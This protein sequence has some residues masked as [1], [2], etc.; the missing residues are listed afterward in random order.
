MEAGRQELG[1]VLS[2]PLEGFVRLEPWPIKRYYRADMVCQVSSR[3][4]EL[5]RLMNEPDIM[6]LAM[7]SVFRISIVVHF[8]S[9][10]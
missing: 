5:S 2:Y 10:Q 4:Q 9:S 8:L 3:G 7:L 1:G 6:D